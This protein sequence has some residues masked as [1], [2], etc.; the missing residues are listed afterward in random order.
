M[1]TFAFIFGIIFLA[2]GIGG[3]IPVL[4]E[5][6]LFLKV[7]RVNAWLNCLHIASGIYALI[8]ASWDEKSSMKYFR[9]IGVLYAIVALS[10]FAYGDR[11]IYRFFASN[12]PDTWFHVIASVA[13][14][15]LGY[16][17][18]S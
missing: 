12:A 13:A 3:F 9:F 6:G 18:K 7:F 14:L 1:R 4:V 2:F 17:S 5:E 16:G 15:I 11:E 8:A 10:G